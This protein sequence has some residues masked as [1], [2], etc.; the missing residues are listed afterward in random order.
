MRKTSIF[1]IGS[2]A[3][4]LLVTYGFR[5]GANAT[6]KFERET[7]DRSVLDG[8]AY[9]SDLATPSGRVK[10]DIKDGHV[11]SSLQ[12]T[13]SYMEAKNQAQ[14]EVPIV[15]T[16]IQYQLE[17]YQLQ[18]PI[19]EWSRTQTNTFDGCGEEEQ[20]YETAS[21][22]YILYDDREVSIDTGLMLKATSDVLI[23]KKHCVY[24]ESEYQEPMSL[25]SFDAQ[26]Y[27]TGENLIEKDEGITYFMPLQ[28]SSMIGENHV[29]YFDKDLVVKPLITLETNRVYEELHL[30]NDELIVLSHDEENFYLTCFDKM[31]N[32]VQ[33]N[34][35]EYRKQGDSL[36]SFTATN[37]L[38]WQDDATCW[39]YDSKNGSVQTIPLE[40]E[41]IC[42]QDIYEK[43]DILY[44]A[45]AKIDGWKQSLHLS[46]YQN[47]NKVYSGEVLLLENEQVQEQFQSNPVDVVA[48]GYFVR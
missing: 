29:F 35:F 11:S 18:N 36:E 44:L 25:S 31:G 3:S 45:S 46:A 24:Y 23:T 16:T 1:V 7:G 28:T 30:I 43:N 42:I 13:K 8:I 17:L 37:Y 15:G 26:R 38:V 21:I 9:H 39:I 14:Q 19:S 22:R 47:Q 20:Q 2:L 33:E 48:W 40:E 27:F 5:I 6:F 34:S 32:R 10:V 4:F 41:R 12:Q